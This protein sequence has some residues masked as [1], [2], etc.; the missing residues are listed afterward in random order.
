M[1]LKNLTLCFCPGTAPGEGWEAHGKVRAVLG[2]RGEERAM[3]DPES[4]GARPVAETWKPTIQLS[5]DS[6]KLG[7]S[8]TVSRASSL[9]GLEANHPR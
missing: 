4:R 3:L 7:V 5:P 1:G 6:H 9:L 8:V 2:K